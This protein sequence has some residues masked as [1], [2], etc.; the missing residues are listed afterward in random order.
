MSP[1][2]LRANVI[3]TAA[4][5][6]FVTINRLAGA[7]KIIRAVSALLRVPKRVAVAALARHLARHLAQAPHQ[8]QVR[9][10]ARRAPPVAAAASAIGTALITHCVTTKPVAGVMKA[11]K[12]VSA[13]A[14]VIHRAV[15]VGLVR[16]L[17]ALARPVLLALLARHLHLAVLAEPVT[18]TVLATPF[19]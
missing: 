7:G 15:A 19:V 10:L 8:V 14:P 4:T 9:H 6:L 18:T 2:L 11:A 12:A 1:P 17:A 16:L 13:L 5:T 3:G